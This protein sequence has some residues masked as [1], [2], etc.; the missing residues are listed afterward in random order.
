MSAGTSSRSQLE[1]WTRP[2]GMN[3]GNS[4]AEVY[5]DLYREGAEEEGMRRKRE[6]ENAL[7][8]LLNC[9]LMMV[10]ITLYLYN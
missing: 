2:L 4:L 8:N 7:I 10:M 5:H 6:L 3:C 1:R 9:V